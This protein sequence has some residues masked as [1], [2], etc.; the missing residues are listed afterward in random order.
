M[1]LITITPYLC[2]TDTAAAIAFYTEA[3]GAVETDI[4]IE[5]DGRIGHAELRI[6][7]AALLLS[8]EFPEIGVLSPATIGGSPIMLVLEVP[9]VDAVFAQAVAAGAAPDR[10]VAG[11]SLRNGKIID[12]FGHRWMILTRK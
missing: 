6:G 10:P 11:E 8:D 5:E 12:P 3:F 1:S 2:F 4:I 9:D 7:E